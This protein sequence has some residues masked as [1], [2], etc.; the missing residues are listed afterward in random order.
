[1]IFKSFRGCPG[2]LGV[3][4]KEFR[5]EPQNQNLANPGFSENHNPGVYNPGAESI[6]EERESCGIF[7]FTLIAIC[8]SRLQSKNKLHA[9]ISEARV[10]IRCSSCKRDSNFTRFFH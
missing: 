7:E 3:L 8:L 5:T 1:M 10:R 2:K 9:K 4:A 6:V